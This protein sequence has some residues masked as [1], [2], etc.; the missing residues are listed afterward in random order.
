MPGFPGKVRP[1]LEILDSITD[2]GSSHRSNEDRCGAAGAFAWVI[3]GATGVA[4]G[5]LVD[6]QGSDAAWL[7][8]TASQAFERFATAPEAH[9]RPLAEVVRATIEELGAAFEA[10]RLREPKGRYEWPSAGFLLVSESAQGLRFANLGDCSLL[11]AE[12]GRGVR[13][14]G[15]PRRSGEGE[16]AKKLKVGGAGFA[17]AHFS[18]ETLDH[19]RKAR[20]R[21]NTEGGYWILGLGPGEEGGAFREC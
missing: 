15:A 9:S 12:A 14:F 13:Q 2:A 7:A 18:P 21:Q 19:L 1:M 3:D 4:E 20:N 11:V 8:A 17:D 10:Q 5:P 16:A 6:P